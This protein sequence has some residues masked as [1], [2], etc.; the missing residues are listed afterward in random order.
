MTEPKTDT[1]T[2][3]DAVLC[4]D[5]PAADASTR[6]VLLIIGSPR[7]AAGFA[8]LAG[9]CTDRT[10]VTYDPRGADRSQRTDGAGR[11]GAA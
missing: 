4:Y 8:S 9:H 11:L 2:V 10:V 6:P 7:G 3:P 5:V 1:L